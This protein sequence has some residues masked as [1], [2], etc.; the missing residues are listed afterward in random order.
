M[1]LLII[2]YFWIIYENNV[3]SNSLKFELPE[4]LTSLNAINSTI[5]LTVAPVVN[6]TVVPFVAVNSV[7][8]SLVPFKN[9]STYPTV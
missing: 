8:S 5:S 1:P 4:R 6:V 3:A 7:L 9:T 2:I